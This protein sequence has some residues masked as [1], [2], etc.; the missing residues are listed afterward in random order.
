MKLKELAF[1]NI[2]PNREFKH[3][4]SNQ[5]AIFFYQVATPNT[6]CSTRYVDGNYQVE[7]NYAIACMATLLYTKPESKSLN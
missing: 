5:I 4:I 7:I 3:H 2:Q 6:M 1:L